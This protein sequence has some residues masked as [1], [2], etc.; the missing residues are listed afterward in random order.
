MGVV[1]V[2]LCLQ[3]FIQERAHAVET[4]TSSDTLDSDGARA[5]VL[6][7]DSAGRSSGAM[8]ASE[9]VYGRA[10]E[11][12]RASL[13]AEPI[14]EDIDVLGA[15][16][17]DDSHDECSDVVNNLDMPVGTWPD[18]LDSFH[19]DSRFPTKATGRS[20]SDGTDQSCSMTSEQSTESP[21]P[22]PLFGSSIKVVSHLSTSEC[23]YDQ[24]I[25]ATLTE[26]M[27]KRRMDGSGSSGTTDES[28]RPQELPQQFTMDHVGHFDAHFGRAL[29]LEQLGRSFVDGSG[30]KSL[31]SYRMSS[32]HRMSTMASDV[33]KQGWLMKRGEVM[34]SWHRRWFTLRRMYVHP[35]A[36]LL[37]LPLKQCLLRGSY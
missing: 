25:A 7:Q 1:S 17:T 22:S 6:S 3:S 32:Y 37:L 18:V 4:T 30:S 27:N 14:H 24:R 10:T 33:I 15:A 2:Y 12:L 11:Q 19:L 34:P 20:M 16:T 26:S 13:A 5:S 31:A 8:L 29:Y 36:S 21:L 35:V 23:S 9:Y 28:P